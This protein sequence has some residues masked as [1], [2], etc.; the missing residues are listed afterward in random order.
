MAALMPGGALRRCASG[1]ASTALHASDE[2]TASP[3]AVISDI[4]EEVS[5]SVLTS[6]SAGGAD[7]VTSLPSPSP[8]APA[9]FQ[10]HWRRRRKDRARLC[11]AGRTRRRETGAACGDGRA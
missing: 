4:D 8:P 10:N 3:C 2:G 5:H 1:A 7:D 9:R 11:P 6:A